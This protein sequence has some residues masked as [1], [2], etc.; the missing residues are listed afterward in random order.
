MSDA[1]I[2]LNKTPVFL[3][4]GFRPFFLG[5]AII[6]ILNTVIWI[7]YLLG[8]I[9]IN[10]IFSP[11][12]WHLHEMI[13]GFIGAA[14]AGFLLTAIPNWT[15]RPPLKGL[16][17]LSLFLLWVLGR[18]VIFYSEYTG[19]L[20]AALADLPFF[21]ILSLYIFREI[22]IQGNKKNFPIAML[23]FLFGIANGLMHLETNLNIEPAQYGY[24]FSLIL[25]SIL[26][27]II[28]GRIIPNFTASW[29]KNNGNKHL[30]TLMN[31]FD[32]F[33]IFF[34][35]FALLSWGI[36]PENKLTGIV[37]VVSGILNGVRLSRWKFGAIY[38]NPILVILQIAYAWLVLGLLLLGWF[39]IIS[40][41]QYD[42]PIHAITVGGFAS[43]IIAVM[44]R[45]SLGHTGRAIRASKL[46]I[47]C[48]IF[49]NLSVIFRLLASLTDVVRNELL[50]LSAL[51][52]IL[53]FLVFI[54]QYGR[55]YFSE[56]KS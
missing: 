41:E 12:N 55:Y 19:A 5:S 8:Y 34:S 29:L 56:R 28:G 46:T 54:Y 49:I 26:V 6:A 53:T 14:I 44:T 32:L 2:R 4:N 24:R 33:C 47:S 11:T 27:M 17:L 18:I 43:M 30:P 45:A 3:R 21:F 38:T 13:F 16:N 40:F 39:I 50:F 37:I 35:I 7:A 15:G 51:A 10:S 25:I 48:Y 36:L 22:Y 23:V 42:L 20:F 9:E 1:N 52:W 31:K